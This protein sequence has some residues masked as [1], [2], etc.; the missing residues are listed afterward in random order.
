VRTP[1]FR[2]PLSLSVGA[3]AALAL[4][5]C[6]SA[7][8][9][10]VTFFPGS[11]QEFK[12]P[13]GVSSVQISAFGGEG[14]PGA[15]CGD[16]EGSG[17]GGSGAQVA[18]VVPVSSASTLYVQFPAGGTGGTGA[19]DTPS[20]SLDGGAGGGASEVLAGASEPLLIA[21]GG[22]GGGA[23][24][25]EGGIFE[26][27]SED[28]GVGASAS[29]SV[30]DGTAGELHFGSSV[31]VQ[32]EGGGGGESSKGGAAGVFESAMASWATAAE[33]GIL[34]YGG[35]GGTWNGA[36]GTPY[37]SAGGGGGSGYYG[38]GGGG[39]GN[40]A[41][42][43]G[44]AGSSFLDASAGVTG[45]V[46]SGAGNAQEVTITYT[47]A[48]APD[49]VITSPASGG[50]YTQAA[51]VATAFSCAEGEGG[52]GIELCIDSNGASAGTGLLET[53]TLG[54]H[55]YELTAT[56]EDGEITSSEISYTV[57]APPI[58]T[59]TASTPAVAATPTVVLPS[60]APPRA[61]CVSKR[62]L[63][64]HPAQHAGL[65]AGVKIKHVEVLLGDRVLA[66]LS[67][68]DPVTKVDLEGLPKGTYEVTLVVLTSRGKTV[69]STIVLHT[70]QERAAT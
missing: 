36:G 14:Q 19:G 37:T 50:I 51:V 10:T 13:V 63:L 12:V 2:R 43:G 7:L 39:L 4:A 34:T 15:L 46:S 47:V 66:R 67:G 62:S 6:A 55:R 65:P 59:V 5:P 28:G 53:E 31:E 16:E 21:G 45:T 22:G 49:A 18:A 27:E 29:S 52:P 26:E 33:P 8:A 56:S 41:G 3:F 9:Q 44:G 38:G 11:S 17:A 70:C 20:C 30:A 68:A 57:E 42:G 25:G 35:V 60:I 32:G 69:R 1:S 23:S 64:I 61:A 24:L 58:T 40:G 48:G 54:A